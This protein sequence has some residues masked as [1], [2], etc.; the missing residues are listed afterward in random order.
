[1]DT[2]HTN[3]K[4]AIQ[5]FS[6]VHSSTC[7]ARDTPHESIAW[8]RG[9]VFIALP[10]LHSQ[11]CPLKPL[12]L[13]CMLFYLIPLNQKFSCQPDFGIHSF[14]QWV[15]IGFLQHEFLNNN[16]LSPSINAWWF[17]HLV[18]NF[19]WTFW[20]LLVLLLLIQVT[21][22]CKYSRSLFTWNNR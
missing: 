18:F 14:S 5:G 21:G 12:G 9:M 7:I 1:M 16:W 10:G 22:C 19:M 6:P 8:T 17:Y 15:A 13:V 2:S 4:Y 3:L 20:A 11:H